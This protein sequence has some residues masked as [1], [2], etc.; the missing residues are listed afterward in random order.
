VCA[1]LREWRHPLGYG[2]L[3]L[4]AEK[5]MQKNAKKCFRKL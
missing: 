4:N 3:Q 2:N 5:K 1:S